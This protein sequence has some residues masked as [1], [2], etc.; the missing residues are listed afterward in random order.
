MYF[1]FFTEYDFVQTVN[2]DPTLPANGGNVTNVP[3]PT[4]VWASWNYIP[5]IGTFRAGNMKPSIGLDHLTS[6]RYLDFLERS[7]GFDTYFNRNNGFQPGLQILNWSQ[8][9]LFTWQLGVFKMN[10]TIQGWNVGDGEYQV[11]GRV[12][13]LPWYQDN[14]RYMMHLGLGMQHDQPDQSTAILRDRWLLRNGPPTLHNT[15]ALAIINGHDQTLINPEFFMNLG[16]LSIQAEYLSGY[17]DNVTSFQTQSQGTVAVAGAPKVFRS[18]TAY[19]Q[20]LY[21]LTGENRPYAKT[22]LHGSGAAPTRVVPFRNASGCRA[23]GARTA[24]AR[25]PGRSASATPTPT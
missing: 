14:G 11:N 3:V 7:P 21:F 22:G 17:L 12:T 2:V 10:N 5:W 24:S 9:E 19:I 13:W 1:D 15:V 16:P 4:D 23:R 25:G 18:Q 20:A 8:N 6:S